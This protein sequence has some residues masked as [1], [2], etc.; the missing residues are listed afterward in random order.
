M[1]E[2]VTT[3]GGWAAKGPRREEGRVI[4][5]AMNGRERNLEMKRDLRK[6]WVTF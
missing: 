2:V 4:L 1:S 6:T 5:L 3:T